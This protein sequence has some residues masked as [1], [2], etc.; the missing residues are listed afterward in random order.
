VRGWQIARSF[1]AFHFTRLYPAWA[2]WLPPHVPTLEP[3]AADRLQPAYAKQGGE[4]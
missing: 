1:L 2:N 3:A 4:E